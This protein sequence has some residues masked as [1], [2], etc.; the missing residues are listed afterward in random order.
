MG[1]SKVT[2]VLYHSSPH[3][4]TWVSCST[5]LGKLEIK[6]PLFSANAHPSWGPQA[7]L[8]KGSQR[9]SE[10]VVSHVR[11]HCTALVSGKGKQSRL[12]VSLLLQSSDWSHLS[13][14]PMTSRATLQGAPSFLFKSLLQFKQL[15]CRLL[16][17]YSFLH[18]AII[19]APVYIWNHRFYLY[20]FVW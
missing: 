13:P 1:L 2:E 15:R 6:H 8:S 17:N 19:E 12:S 4:L 5:G 16:T 3:E 20:I 9:L 18:W 11:S 14:Y 10:P 7:A